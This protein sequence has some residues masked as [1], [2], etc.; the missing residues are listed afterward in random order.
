[1]VNIYQFKSNV[2]NKVNIEHITIL[3]CSEIR[4]KDRKFETKTK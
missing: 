4:I 1:M 3:G 2:D